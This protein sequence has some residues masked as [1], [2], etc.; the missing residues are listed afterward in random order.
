MS[1]GDY[2][3]VTVTL[4]TGEVLRYSREG[5]PG[6]VGLFE[7]LVQSFD[8]ILYQVS[9][10]DGNVPTPLFKFRLIDK[11]QKLSR[12]V[13]RG[14][15]IVGARVDAKSTVSDEWYFSGR[16]YAM[17]PDGDLHWAITC[18]PRDQALTGDC[19]ATLINLQ[20]FPFTVED[21][22]K[23]MAPW[24]W[25]IFDSV[26]N[27]DA[28]ALPTYLV[29]VTRNWYLVAFGWVTVLRIYLAGVYV[30]ES[31]T[32]TI[33]HETING[34]RYTLIQFQ[35]AQGDVAITADAIGYLEDASIKPPIPR[36]NTIQL[37]YVAEP[38]EIF[39]HAATNLLFLQNKTGIFI[40]NSTPHP[41]VDAAAFVALNPLVTTIVPY[42]VSVYMGRPTTGYQWIQ[43]WCRAMSA[44]VWWDNQGRLTTGPSFPPATATF[45]DDPWMREDHGHI[46]FLRRMFE[47]REKVSKLVSVYGQ[48]PASPDTAHPISANVGEDGRVGHYR[49]DSDFNPAFV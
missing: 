15:T 34:R 39:I 5:F 41:D 14:E 47:A 10:E 35:S 48:F 12:R 38:G 36:V 37:D 46:L 31:P 43:N 9:D 23:T 19:P 1:A 33:L 42:R 25:G 17:V 3:G 24:P 28:G 32:W 6:P 7:P 4:R 27:G 11:E 2:V 13:A 26:G 40:P 20:D 30:P 44:F 8:K 49:I 29:D 21:N 22:L 18:R 45:I 16:V